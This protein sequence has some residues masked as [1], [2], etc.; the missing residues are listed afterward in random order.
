MGRGKRQP[1]ADASDPWAQNGSVTTVS[2]WLAIGGA[3]FALMVA[4]AVL[5]VI[6]LD[7]HDDASGTTTTSSSSTSVSTTTSI[8]TTTA[9]PPPGPPSTLVGTVTTSIPQPP[10]SEGPDVDA[11]VGGT[12]MSDADAT[13]VLSSTLDED[14]AGVDA[15][16]DQWVPQVSSKRPGL[17]VED[18]DRGA[19]TAADVLA[20]HLGYERRYN[21]DG[22]GVRL[23]LSDDFNFKS[24]G[25]YVT[26]VDLRFATGEEANAWCAARNIGVDDCFAKRLS[27]SDEWRGSVLPRK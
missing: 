9:P 6:L 26:V 14:R 2:P 12:Y 22:I 8:T 27:R 7:Q 10:P 17:D 15:L 23:L 3:A 5:L 24:D 16:I 13:A 1:L 19:Y 21:A 11:S 4:V 20:D 18:D 25:Y